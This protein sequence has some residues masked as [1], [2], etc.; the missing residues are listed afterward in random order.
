MADLFEPIRPIYLLYRDASEGMGHYG[1]LVLEEVVAGARAG[2]HPG[3]KVLKEQISPCR[4]PHDSNF[5][6]QAGPI[7]DGVEQEAAA[8]LC[9]MLRHLFLSL[10]TP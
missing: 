3:C 10:F 9:S 8:S 4:Q 1:R 5:L 7:A 2:G 6:R